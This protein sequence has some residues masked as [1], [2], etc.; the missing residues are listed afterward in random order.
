VDRSEVGQYKDLGGGGRVIMWIVKQAKL[1]ARYGWP[2]SEDKILKIS[3]AGVLR[4]CFQI[5]GKTYVG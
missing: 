3:S 2:D 5:V 1:E 4:R